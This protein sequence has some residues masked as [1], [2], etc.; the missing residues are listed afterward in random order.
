LFN[1]FDINKFILK[2]Q[3]FGFRY[4]D[5]NRPVNSF[6][7][8]RLVI[9]PDRGADLDKH[10][11]DLRVRINLYPLVETDN[12][13]YR[14]LPVPEVVENICDSVPDPFL[15]EVVRVNPLAKYI[16]KLVA[17]SRKRAF[18]F[19]NLFRYKLRFSLFVV[20]KRYSVLPF[21]SRFLSR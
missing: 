5:V 11:Q 15:C 16:K 21:L 6:D 17:N 13:R 20:V 2:P 1:C 19:Y 9:V 18:K 10:S 3:R 12:I 8:Y 7:L 4:V 14:G